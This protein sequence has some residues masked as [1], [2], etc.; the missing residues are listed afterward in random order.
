MTK[1]TEPMM[2]AL[3]WLR[4]RNGTG[5][6]DRNG[7]LL[8]GNELG[9]FMRTTWNK[10]GAFGLVIIEGKRATVTSAGLKLKIGNVKNRE[11]IESRREDCKR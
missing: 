5:V 4:E 8:A 7:V 6:F 10:L 2:A 3:K 9:P 1:I 11:S